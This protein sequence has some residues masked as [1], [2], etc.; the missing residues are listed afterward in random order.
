[1]KQYQPS[2]LQ[3]IGIPIEEAVGMLRYIDDRYGTPDQAWAYWQNVGW[4]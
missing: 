1:M 4:Y 2:G 3:G